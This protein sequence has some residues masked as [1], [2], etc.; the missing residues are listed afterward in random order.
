VEA[1]RGTTTTPWSTGPVEGQ[2]GRLK[3][4]KRM[5]FGRAGFALLR[6]RVLARF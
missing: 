4:L 3:L 2:I 5:M 6:Q 1:L